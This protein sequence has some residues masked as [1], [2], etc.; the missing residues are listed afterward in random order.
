MAVITDIFGFHARGLGRAASID[1]AGTSNSDAETAGLLTLE[2]HDD[3]FKSLMR[4]VEKLIDTDPA[5]A[6]RLADGARRSGV[7]SA[8]RMEE[9]LKNALNRIIEV[10]H[11]DREL[12]AA[13]TR[14]TLGTTVTPAIHVP[15]LA[16]SPAMP[17]P[18]SL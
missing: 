5:E 6:L 18:G 16:F 4:K 7:F 2:Y 14:G 15:S 11:Q 3:P 17:A 1:V 13:F 12:G 8:S 9:K 10:L